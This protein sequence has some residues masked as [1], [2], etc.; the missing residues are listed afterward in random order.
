LSSKTFSERIEELNSKLKESN[1][2]RESDVLINEIDTL[3]CVLGHMA[4][5]KYVDKARGIE[6]AE[7]KKNFKQANHLREELCDLHDMGSEISAKI[8]KHNRNQL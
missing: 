2:L 7:A 5:P 8:Q 1:H 3:E 6:I 4:N